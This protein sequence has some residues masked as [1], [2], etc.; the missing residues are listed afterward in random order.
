MDGDSA[1]GPGKF[2]H[3]CWDIVKTNLLRLVQAFFSCHNLPKSI[4]HTNLFLIPK[5][6][7]ANKYCN[8]RPISLSNFI[9]KIISRIVHD[10]MET[11]LPKLISTNQSG[12]VKGRNII[13]NVLPTQEIVTDIRLRG[14]LANVIIKLDMT[15]AYDRVS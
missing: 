1:S 14:K 8:M 4:T 13:E 7:D 6:N 5:K 10:R 12:F 15:E 9:S 2:Y 11:I 3:V